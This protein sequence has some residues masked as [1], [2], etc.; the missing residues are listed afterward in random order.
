[1]PTTAT[2]G[3][4]TPGTPITPMLRT[5]TMPTADTLTRHTPTTAITA[6]TATPMPITATPLPF[7]ATRR[8]PTRP[9]AIPRTDTRTHT[10]TN[11]A[12]NTHA[13]DS[14]EAHIDQAHGDVHVDP[15]CDVGIFGGACPPHE[16]SHEDIPVALWQHADVPHGDRGLHFDA[17]FDSPAG[18]HSDTPH[19]DTPHTDRS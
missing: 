16:D 17:H 19:A 3:T 11:C 7:T 4:A 5:P 1:M 2:V 14:D 12:V 15:F 8:T 18:T 13:A 10:R 6:T 9:T